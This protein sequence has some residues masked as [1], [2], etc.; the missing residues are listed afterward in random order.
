MET[1]K[2]SGNP[3]KDLQHTFIPPYKSHTHYGGRWVTTDD[4]KERW[5]AY[6]PPLEDTASLPRNA[7]HVQAAPGH[8]LAE[9][10]AVRAQHL[11]RDF[12]GG[13]ARSEPSR[14]RLGQVFAQGDPILEFAPHGGWQLRVLVPESAATDVTPQQIGTFVAAARP[15]HGL[16]IQLRQLDGAAQVVEGRNVFV[17]R[18]KVKS[19]PSWLRSG[20][21]GVAKVKTVP[22][23]IWWVTFHG[24]I[25]W[26]RLRFWL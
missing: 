2:W 13:A 12:P 6:H 20:M 1:Q 23:P 24:V 11:P 15:S 18:A 3:S 25:D 22:K 26:T 5:S 19:A 9:S 4:G 21:R 7:P 8:W 16:P 17:A 14:E 10:R